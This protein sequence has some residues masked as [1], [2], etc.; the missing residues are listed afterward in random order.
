MTEELVKVRIKAKDP[1]NSKP[2]KKKKLVSTSTH[3]RKHECFECTPLHLALFGYISYVFIFLVGY[4]REFIWGTG[5]LGRNVK[6]LTEGPDRKGYTSL[7]ASFESFYTRNVYRRMKDVFNRPICSAPGA[8]VTLVE[9]SSP[10]HFW[11]WHMKEASSKRSIN[12]ASY[13]YL[14]FAENEGICTERAIQAA[15]TF[16]LTPSSSR[17]ELG[18]WAIHKK[19]EKTVARFLGTEDAFAVGMG[20]ATNALNLPRLLDQHSLALSDEKNHA[21]I[22]LGLRLSAATVKV[23]KHNN[24]DNLEKVLRKAIIH[25]HPKTRRPW[26]KIFIIVEGVYSMEGSIVRL[27]EILTLKKKYGAYIYLDE[28]HSVG[29]MGSR[30]RGVVDYFGLDPRDVDIMMGTFT[31]SFGAAGGYIAGSKNLIDYLRINSQV[32][33]SAPLVHAMFV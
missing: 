18:L 12:M 15:K 5:P 26:K 4:I 28:A 30:G 24:V 29:A 22:I 17:Q 2:E 13:N 23:F 8:Q 6:S 19:L 7:Y 20:F 14:G 25:G 31:K 9:R 3:S 11:T 1:I 32:I 27:P 16:G 33:L 10:D 21:S